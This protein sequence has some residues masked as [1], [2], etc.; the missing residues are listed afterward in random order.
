MFT[1]GPFLNAY[2]N[3]SFDSISYRYPSTLHRKKTN[4][5]YSTYVMSFYAI[6]NSFEYDIDGKGREGDI[7]IHREMAYLKYKY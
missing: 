4:T 3:Y 7:Y 1:L 5:F 2:F 6:L